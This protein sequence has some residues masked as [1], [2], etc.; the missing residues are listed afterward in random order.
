MEILKKLIRIKSVTGEEGEI[1]K[2]ILNL[3]ASYGLKPIPVKGNVVVL[4]KGVDGNKC[5]VFNSHVDTVSTGDIKLWHED[6]FSGKNQNGKIYGLG[7]SDNK[8]S[9]A[10]LLQLARELS[11]Q[12]PECDIILTF[13]V[14]EEVDGHGTNETVKF[15]SA[16]YLKAYKSVSAI[17]CEPTGLDCIG[18]A[19]KG[20]LFLKITTVGESGH[21]SKPIKLGKHS[22]IKMYNIVTKLEKLGKSWK[23]RYKNQTLGSPTIGL[24]TSIKAGNETVPNK[25]PDKCDATFDIRTIPEMHDLAY[26][27]IKRT[28]RDLGKVEY[29]YPPVAFGFTDKEAVIAKILK[30]AA[31]VK[32]VAF[33]GSTDMPFFTQKG[34]PTVIFGP[35]ETKM[36]HKANEF[37]YLNKIEKCTKIFIQIIKGYNNFN[38]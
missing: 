6:P 2:F 4:I 5:L 26:K 16:K 17:V 38:D 9:V 12:K 34:V 28:I 14:G 21:G 24:V 11:V 20:N 32:F 1:Q 8:S 25:F 22:V 29:L 7:A 30:K 19:H 23:K 10:V 13:T 3:L 33:P 31:K 27:E 15:L 37:C 18:L 35:G 36:M